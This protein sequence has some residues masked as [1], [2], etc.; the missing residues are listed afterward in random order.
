MLHIAR[1]LFVWL[2]YLTA[3]ALLL[4]AAYPLHALV[5]ALG[6]VITLTEGLVTAV[7]FLLLMGGLA[8]FFG[9]L[10]PG[11]ARLFFKGLR[12]WSRMVLGLRSIHGPNLSTKEGSRRR[13]FGSFLTHSS[14]HSFK[15]QERDRY[16]A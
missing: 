10:M 13:G 6:A 9:R 3:Q 15:E 4:I 8:L 12:G 14:A 16:E 2:L 11:P 1:G 7:V 5:L